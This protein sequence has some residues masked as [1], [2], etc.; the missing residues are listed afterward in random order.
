MEHTTSVRACTCTLLTVL[1]SV[2][3]I[4]AAPRPAAADTI[5]V[6]WNANPEIT[7][8]GYML[9]VGTQSAT[10]THQIDVGFSTAYAWTAAVAGQRYCFAVSAY[11]ADRSEGLKSSE[12]CGYSNNAPVLIDPGD[13]SSERGQ[14][15]SLQLQGSDPDGTPVSYSAT[16]LP[17][18]LALLASTGYISGT[19]FTAATHTV[20][21]SVS[22]G[23]LTASQTFTWTITSQTAPNPP[24]PNP[25]LPDSTLPTVSITNPTT[26][27]SLVTSTADISG[28]TGGNVVQVT[29]TNDRGGSGT[30]T[31]TTSW[32]ARVPLAM[33][34][35]DITVT[36]R[37]AAGNIAT[38][39]LTVKRR[40]N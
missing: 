37:D 25:T 3:I 6:I 4:T 22:D 31:G 7:V 18:G 9:H 32:T 14:P 39:V 5:T 11:I 23:E 33:G 35:N 30:A 26:S 10:Y 15:T 24:L 40:P 17:P 1:T 28:T 38:D 34:P 19:P 12:V 2:S 8:V 21:A 16:G 29:W 13:Q 36:A 27:D 20:T